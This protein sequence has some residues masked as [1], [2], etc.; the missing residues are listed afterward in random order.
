MSRSLHNYISVWTSTEGWMG[1]EWSLQSNRL[2]CAWALQPNRVGSEWAL[3][4]NSADYAWALQPNRVSSAWALQPN[5]IG[6]TWALHCSPTEWTYM[7]N[8]ANTLLMPW[9]VEI[10][11]RCDRQPA[12]W[13]RIQQCR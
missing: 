6:S 13:C 3:Q 7:Y 4:P 2:D 1:S 5:R 8:W 10:N 11:W 9:E 12:G